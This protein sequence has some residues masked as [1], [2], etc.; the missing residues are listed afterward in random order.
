MARAR[1]ALFGDEQAAAY[2]LLAN[3]IAFVEGRAQR[4]AVP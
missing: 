1:R 3:R 4:R 2:D